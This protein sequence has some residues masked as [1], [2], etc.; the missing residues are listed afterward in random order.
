MREDVKLTG[1]GTTAV[2]PHGG[3]YEGTKARVLKVPHGRGDDRGDICNTTAPRADGDPRTQWQT[4]TRLN[5]GKLLSNGGCN[6]GQRSAW[7]ALQD[8]NHLGESHRPYL[9]D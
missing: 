6:I 8:R 2:A 1:I 7:K 4:S 9:N 3:N 5:P